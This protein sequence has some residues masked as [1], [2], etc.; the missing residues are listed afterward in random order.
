MFSSLKIITPLKKVIINLLEMPLI[1]NHKV[2]SALE[3]ILIISRVELFEI[4]YYANF[5]LFVSIVCLIIVDSNI[6][7]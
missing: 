5:S 2:K 7:I 6:L 1:F 4:N 3:S